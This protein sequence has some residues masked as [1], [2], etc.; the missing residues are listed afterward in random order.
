MRIL[1]LALF[2]IVSIAGCSDEP[3]GGDEKSKV[4]HYLVDSLATDET[5]ALF[6][7][8]QQISQTG[9]LFGHQATTAYGVGWTSEP[10]RSDVKSVCGSY[11][12]VFGWDVGDIGNSANLDGVS[13][14]YMKALIKQAY[15]WG[16]V[17]TISMHLDNPVSGGDAWDNSPAVKEILPG[18]S[19]H[20]SYL[21]TLDRIADFIKDLKDN[22]G[23]AIPIILR[24]YHEHNHT[25]S[26]WGSSACTVS[27]Y[28][29]LWKMTVDYFRDHHNIHQLIYAISPQEIN[30][31]AEYLQRYPGDDYVD[32]LGM[33]SYRLY[34]ADL[35]NELGKALAVL[36]TMAESRGKIAALTEVGYV[37]IPISTWWTNY[38]LQA[39][40]YNEQSKKI[41]WS[42]VW[43]NASTSH[44]FAPY[45]GDPSVPDFI[46]FYNNP[47][48]IFADDLPDMYH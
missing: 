20:D 11:P 44:H 14:E 10:N 47:F 29:S 26:W 46:D 19:H 4:N 23:V 15:S 9:V 35:I 43:R 45:P 17:N 7:N 3:T 24:P 32:I 37:N 30:T 41:A 34:R 31:E 38:L 27:E 40:N 33:D 2:L 13:F 5:V 48:T 6:L 1:I 28:D 21:A 36:S 42:L 16:A 39:I 18:Q 22:N 12:A 25:W 8:L